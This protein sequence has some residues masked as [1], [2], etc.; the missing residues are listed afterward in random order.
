MSPVIK[1]NKVSFQLLL[2]VLSKMEHLLHRYL[3]YIV[4]CFLFPTSLTIL[5][6][7]ASCWF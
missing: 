1:I 6:E 4:L 7:L 3:A 2:A 5:S